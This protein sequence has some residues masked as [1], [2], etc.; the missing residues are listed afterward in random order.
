MA[1]F[2]N[3]QAGTPIALRIQGSWASSAIEALYRSH[4]ISG[5]GDGTFKPNNA[6]KRVEA[7]VLINAMLFRGPL[8]DIA[9]M[10]PDVP[11]GY[12]G[13][14]QIVEASFSHASSRNDEG[15]EHFIK[16]IAD[17]VKEEQVN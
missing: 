14:G 2:L 4:M 15:Q 5:Y 8:T 1:R 17:Q 11:A 9:P 7:V 16:Q 6:I 10:F 3:L 13:F 12:W